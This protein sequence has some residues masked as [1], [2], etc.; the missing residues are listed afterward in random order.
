[1]PH[2]AHIFAVGAGFDLPFFNKT[3]LLSKPQKFASSLFG[4]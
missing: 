3:R 4:G 1:L 2:S